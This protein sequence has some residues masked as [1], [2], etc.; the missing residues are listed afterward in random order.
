MKKLKIKVFVTIFSILSLFTLAIILTSTM[1]YY[2]ERKNTISDII[3]TS[4]RTLY[5]RIKSNESP[6]FP[7]DNPNQDIRNIYLD[8]TIY[9]I[10]LDEE[11][12]YQE[13]IN[14][15]NNYNYDVEE[16]KN[17]ASNIIVTHTENYYVG[18]LKIR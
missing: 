17:V 16:I 10:I 2:I 8:F 13:I 11:G 14:N 7:I 5:P 1:R 18:N 12:N 6:D 15:S 9:T 4:Q 3:K